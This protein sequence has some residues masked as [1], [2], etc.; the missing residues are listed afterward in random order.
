MLPRLVQQNY[1]P[2]LFLGTALTAFAWLITTNLN[3]LP[4]IG[5]EGIIPIV[6][7]NL[8]E[9][10]RPLVDDGRNFFSYQ[11]TMGA[12]SSDVLASLEYRYPPLLFY[13]IASGFLLFGENELGARIMPAFFAFGSM[14]LFWSILRREFPNRPWF[15][16]VA[17]ALACFSPMIVLS[18]RAVGYNTMAMF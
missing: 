5:D 18:A 16:V 15:S 4:L 7:R 8:L 12:N 3:Y 9:F 1:A 11:I 6:A 10:G 13:S 2:S 17:V 14:L